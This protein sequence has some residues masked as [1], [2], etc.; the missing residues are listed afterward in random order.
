MDLAYSRKSDPNMLH[1]PREVG[2]DL[3][4][5]YPTNSHSYQLYPGRSDWIR[6]TVRG[7]SL[8]CYI[9][10]PRRSEW[11]WSVLGCQTRISYILNVWV[12]L[13]LIY[14]RKLD[15]NLGILWKVGPNQ[16][17]RRNSDSDLSQNRPDPQYSTVTLNTY[18]ITK[19]TGYRSTEPVSVLDQMYSSDSTANPPIKD[20]F[21]T[22]LCFSFLASS[23]WTFSWSPTSGRW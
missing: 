4:I 1:I 10:V 20:P 16:V 6:S 8:I 15:L 11:I 12:W 14:S 3:V 7:W 5:W 2:L 9:L 23:S 17:Y 13:D 19:G 22:C 21:F 18:S